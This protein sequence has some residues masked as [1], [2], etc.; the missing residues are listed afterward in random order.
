MQRFHDSTEHLV[1]IS[2]IIQESFDKLMEES[3]QLERHA[4][5]VD[6][7]QTKFIAEFEAAYEVYI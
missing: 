6:E 3:K 5:T 2:D 1:N 4:S 7:I